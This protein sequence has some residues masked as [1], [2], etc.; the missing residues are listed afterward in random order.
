MLQ[1]SP[2]WHDQKLT[3]WK[4]REPHMYFWTSET[5]Y[6]VYRSPV[7]ARDYQ[8]RPWSHPLSTY[9]TFVLSYHSANW[10]SRSHLSHLCQGKQLR[11][12]ITGTLFRLFFDSYEFL[13]L[14]T[15][16]GPV[17]SALPMRRSTAWATAACRI[18][19]R[20]II[21]YNVEWLSTVKSIIFYNFSVGFRYTAMRFVLP[22]LRN[23]I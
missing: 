23:A 21:Y 20:I 19:Q 3:S 10:L 2:N 11:K 15:G 12:K 13:K 9:F 4:E 6:A 16:I 17:T 5:L 18:T 14:P 8:N 1:I 22:K 7:Y